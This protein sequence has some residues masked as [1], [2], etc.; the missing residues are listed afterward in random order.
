M[1]TPSAPPVSK[2]QVV[3]D[4]GLP[5]QGDNYSQ[6]NGIDMEDAELVSENPEWQV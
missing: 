5:L 1:H 3:R 2:P 6:N 4:A